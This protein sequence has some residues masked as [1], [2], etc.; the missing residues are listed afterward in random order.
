MDGYKYIVQDEGYCGGKPRIAGS[1]MAVQFIAIEYEGMG[2]SP[3]EICYNHPGLSLAE[4]HAA[5]SYYYDH[6]VEIDQRI[7]E[8]EEYA[9]RMKAE[10]DRKRASHSECP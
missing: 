5:L 10:Q 7:R 3:A 4:V 6:K 8:G 1:R 2:W 9:D